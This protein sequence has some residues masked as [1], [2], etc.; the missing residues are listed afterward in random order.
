[1]F[2]LKQAYA[3]QNVDKD[4]SMALG[5]QNAPAVLGLHHM[6]A[7]AHGIAACVVH[8]WIEYALDQDGEMNLFTYIFHAYIYICIY[9]YMYKYIRIRILH[10]NTHTLHTYIY[11]HISLLYRSLQ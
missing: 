5:T 3:P 1:M 8:G 7:I 4:Q 6:A 9:M 2:L 10:N 11:I